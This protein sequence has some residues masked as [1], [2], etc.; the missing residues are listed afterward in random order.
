MFVP[1]GNAKIPE[2][3][4]RCA[5]FQFNRLSIVHGRGAGSQAGCQDLVSYPHARLL[6]PAEKRPPS[7]PHERLLRVGALTYNRGYGNF[8]ALVT[9]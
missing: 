8:S 6:P 7:P 4:K 5:G 2:I 9:Y 1:Y 3:W